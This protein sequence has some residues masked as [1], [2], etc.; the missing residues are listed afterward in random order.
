MNAAEI[1]R[2]TGLANLSACVSSQLSLA[3]MVLLMEYGISSKQ[4]AL[5]YEEK[6]F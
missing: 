1:K 3:F 2:R 5:F 4:S 6:S